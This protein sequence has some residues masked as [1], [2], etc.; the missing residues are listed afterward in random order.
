MFLDA[1]FTKDWKP[2]Q[3]IT[4][5]DP[6]VPFKRPEHIK[7][8]LTPASISHIPKNTKARIIV[9][10]EHYYIFTEGPTLAE[11]GP[12]TSFTMPQRGQYVLNDEIHIQRSQQCDCGTSLK[13][14]HPFLGVRY[15]PFRT[16]TS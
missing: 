3:K 12:L 7:L 13:G 4:A 16:P 14:F 6:F 10:D 9:T 8:D 15:A 1:L 2:M 5:E 11:Q